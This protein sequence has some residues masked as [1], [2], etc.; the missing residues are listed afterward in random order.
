MFIIVG[1]REKSDKP[2]THQV[3]R[4][5]WALSASCMTHVTNSYN[6]IKVAFQVTNPVNYENRQNLHSISLHKSRLTY[7]M[8]K[9]DASETRSNKC[10]SFVLLSDKANEIESKLLDSNFE[11]RY[12]FV[13]STKR[14]ISYQNNKNDREAELE[15]KVKK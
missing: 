2:I 4:I 15:L 10:S 3:L 11:E 13:T 7:H 9:A 12:S 8:S 6:V 5:K 14:T 1:Y